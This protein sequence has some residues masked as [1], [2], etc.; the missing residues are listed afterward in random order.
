MLENCCKRTFFKVQEYSKNDYVT[1]LEKREIEKKG[2][3]RRERGRECEQ[4]NKREKYI[5]IEKG[6]REKRNKLIGNIKQS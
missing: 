1:K 3:Q 6:R 5:K 2:Y 4:N